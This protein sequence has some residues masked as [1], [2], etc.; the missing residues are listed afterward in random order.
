M[1]DALLVYPEYS[2]FYWGANF[3]VEMLGRKAT[4][5]PLGL[6]TVAAMFP[7]GYDLRVVDMNVTS[8]ET[9]DLEWADLVFTSSMIAQRAS[10]RRRAHPLRGLDLRRRREPD[11]ANRKVAP[12][13]MFQRLASRSIWGQLRKRAN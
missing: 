12:V 6:L 10:L 1:P 7:P 11:G 9:P 13:S 2:P 4:F 5:P 3:A 8:L